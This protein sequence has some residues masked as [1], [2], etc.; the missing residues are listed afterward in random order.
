MLATLRQ[1]ALL[2]ILGALLTDVCSVLCKATKWHWL[3][4]PVER[5]SVFRLQGAIYAGGATS[6]IFPFRLDE[7]VRAYAAARLSRL[8]FVQVLGSMVL[9]RLLDVCVLLCF[10]F[11]LMGLLPLPAWIFTTLLWLGALA[12]GL[13]TV[14]LV[15]HLLSR[16][17]QSFGVFDALLGR[18]AEGSRAIARPRLLALAALF[19][20]AEWLLTLAVS[21]LGT[22]AVGLSLP[23]G[24]LLLVTTLIFGSFA[25]PLTPAGIGTFEVAMGLLLP[26]FYGVTQDQAIP[27]ALLIHTLLLTPMLVVGTTILVLSGIRL[28]EVR[29]WRGEEP[30]G[31]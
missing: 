3:L 30:A 11:V 23:P 24:A 1:V 10:F 28:G 7:A 8:T 17:G 16:S 25:V 29:R 9:E 22:R 4:R 5:V 14:L 6:L 13:I 2:P 20:V 26:L 31:G 19:A 12:G 18:L 21:A 27:L 15:V